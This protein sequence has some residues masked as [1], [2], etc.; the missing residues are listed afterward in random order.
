MKKVA[1]TARINLYARQSAESRARLRDAGGKIF[2]MRMSPVDHRKVRL[3]MEHHGDTKM[4][5]T[6]HRLIERARV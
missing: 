3:L 5:A 6:V 4:S 2:S 1:V